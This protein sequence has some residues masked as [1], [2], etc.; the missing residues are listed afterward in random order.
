MRLL[1]L[2][3]SFQETESS[4]YHAKDCKNVPVSLGEVPA[5]RRAAL[6]K[7]R[8]LIRRYL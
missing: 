5:E 2:G 4:N 8:R 1:P 6:A 3:A 7:L